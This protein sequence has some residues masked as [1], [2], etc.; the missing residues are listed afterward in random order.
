MSELPRAT[1]RA[2]ACPSWQQELARAV[3][4]P[5]ELVR[6]LELP[7]TLLEPA[8]AA[9]RHFPLRVPRGYVARMERGNPNDPLLRQ[10][11]PLATE[12]D[13][14]PGFVADPVGDLSASRGAGILH[15]YY[16]RVLLITTGACAVNCRYC[17]RRHFPYTEANASVE[18]WQPA[19]RY[20]AGHPE[21]EEVILSGG[22]PL[23][24]T[25]RRLAQLTAQLADIPHIRR[26]RV[27]SRLPV[28][29]PAR[30]TD[31][32][33]G[34]F[35][36]NRLQPVMVLHANHANELDETV[37]NA[38]KYLRA[39]GVTILNQTV[40]L[41]GVND[42]ATTL[43]ALNRRLFDSGALPYYLHLLD[44]VAGASHFEITPR[45]ARELHRQIAARLPGYLVPRLVQEI[46]GAPGKSWLPP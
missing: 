26:L 33:L 31:E 45:R 20:I 22:D 28:V 11:L 7:P 25:D 44:R 9:A 24:L 2:T 3:R 42:E 36:G 34:W 21:I 38:I 18:Q 19:L 37:A 23:T 40:L 14:V 46:E 1:L 39:A 35:A 5:G 10:V 15:K 13:T 30:I 12:L 4:D 17:F 32:M 43:T 8:R 29:L 41:R 16:G 6:L 27:H